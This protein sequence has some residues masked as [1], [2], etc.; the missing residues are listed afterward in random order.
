MAD[1]GQSIRQSIGQSIGQSGDRF[2]SQAVDRNRLIDRF[3]V[4]AAQMQAIEQRVF[5]AGMPVAA[6]MEKVAGAIARR[7]MAWQPL[8]RGRR[9]GVLAG[10]GHNGGDALV[11]A[12]ELHLRGYDVTVYLPLFDRL[13]SLTQSHAQYAASLGLAIGTDLAPILAADWI[14]DG[15]FGFGLERPITGSLARAI[16]Q[17]ND[18]GRPIVS[19]D[20]PSGIHTDSGAVLGNAIRADLTL[21]LGLW[22]R[23]LLVDRA[24]DWVGVPELIDFDLPLAD[25]TAVLGDRPALQR[26][27]PELAQLPLRRWAAAHKYQQGHLLL[28]AGSEAYAG[29]AI[30]AALGARASGAGMVT[31][32][33]PARLKPLLV[34]RLPEALVLACPE[35]P[36]GSIESLDSL[37]LDWQRYDAIAAGC[38]LGPAIE[39]V[40][41]ALWHSGC[42]LVLDADGLNGLAAMGWQE[43]SAPV[44]LTPHPGEFRRL[45][46]DLAQATDDPIERAQQAAQLTGAIVVLK[47]ARSVIGEPGGC[48]WIIPESTP[49]LARGGSGDVLAGLLGGLIA[50]R[51]PP[52]SAEWGQLAATAAWWHAQAGLR[53]AAD[54]SILG[55]DGATLAEAL[56]TVARDRQ[57]SSSHPTS[58]SHPKELQ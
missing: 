12:R 42:P 29:A 11:V 10:P 19:I 46:P 43:R 57:P 15:L 7:V 58:S 52:T 14:V 27:G 16:D 34:A 49:A 39:P 51:Q 3:V 35:T 37:N 9:V 22:K 18:S 1:Q 6:L 31:I 36:T 56:L 32:A 24:L 17:I 28:V 53:A 33:V 13:K 38:G 5:A 45:F 26:M 55:A 40:L 21:C 8:D 47:G 25:I 30:L 44:V 54:R 50:Q 23:G 2:R 4:T 20:L 48:G 41:Q